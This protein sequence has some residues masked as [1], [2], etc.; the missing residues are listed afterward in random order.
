[1]L[2]NWQM[3]PVMAADGAQALEAMETARAA[4]RP[5]HVVLL[6]GAMPGIDGF[7][8]A[9]RIREDPSLAGSVILMVSAAHYST[10]FARGHELHVDTFLS[11]P[12]GHSE[13]LDAIFSVLG[14]CA[15]EEHLA[16]VP[17]QVSGTTK[18][19]KL[20]ILLAEDNPVN[21]RLAVRLLEKAGHTVVVAVTGTEVLLKLK[22]SSNPGFD[23]VLMDIQMPEMDGM[24]ATAVIRAGERASGEHIPIIAMTAHA[25]RGD[26]EAYL[27]G[28]MDG[29]VSKPV[30]PPKLFAEL[31]RVLGGTGSGAILPVQPCEEDEHMD[32]SALLERVEGDHDLLVEMIN[33]FLADAPHLLTAMHAGRWS[34]G[35]CMPLLQRLAHSMKGAAGNFSANVTTTAAGVLEKAA[36]RGD[37]ESITASLAALEMAA[38]RLFPVLAEIC[39]GVPK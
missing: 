37:R 39:Q 6:D 10:D 25:M 22:N 35:D 2:T 31:E 16:E 9:K 34:V 23:V 5:F 7:G 1:M 4:R 14:I 36:G 38:N 11:K 33:L 15:V 30:H 3:H 26:K 13:L 27:A 20:N 12:V 17:P 32:R 29:Y 24:E 8:V 19:R 28:G 21:K 18:V